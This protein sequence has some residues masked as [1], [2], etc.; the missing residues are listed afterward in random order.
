MLFTMEDARILKLWVDGAVC[1]GALKI[2]L[3]PLMRSLGESIFLPL[4]LILFTRED[5]G[6]FRWQSG[7]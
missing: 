6:V 2:Y 7:L 3:L 1:D 5:V 4:P